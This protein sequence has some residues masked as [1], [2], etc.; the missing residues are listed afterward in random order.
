MKLPF[1]DAVE[2]LRATVLR[3]ELAPAFL[4]VVT[5]TRSLQSG[6]AFLALRGD[7]FDGHAFTSEAVRRGAVALVVERAEAAAG[8][9]T[10]LV[11]RDSLQAYMQLAGLARSRFSGEVLG[12]TGSAGKTTT[13][14]F[15]AQLLQPRFGDRVLAAPANENNEIGVSK[16][17]LAADDENHSALVVEMGARKYGDVAALVEIARPDVGVLTNVGD[18]HLEIVG[19]RERLEETK[20][21]L[22]GR[23]AR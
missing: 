2:R 23:G 7:R 5:D 1:E 9:V 20:W 18:A 15:A 11:V 22:F 10:A 17:L 6:D 4:R 14:A 8:D 19:T 16:L 13:K 12:I 21:A 3:P